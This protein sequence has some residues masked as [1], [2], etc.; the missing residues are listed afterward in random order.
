MKSINL[1]K[2]Q[3]KPF[4]MSSSQIEMESV[5]ETNIKTNFSNKGLKYMVFG[6]W[7][8]EHLHQKNILSDELRDTIF[9]ELCLFA[10]AEE[11]NVLYDSFMDNMN[12]TQKSMKKFISCNKPKTRK[13][14]KKQVEKKPELVETLVSL[15]N[16]IDAGAAVPVDATVSAVPEEKKEK[17][18]YNRKPKDGAT[19]DETPTTVVDAVPVE[20]K[21][22][23]KYNRKPTVV[24][25]P[26]VDVS[27]VVEV[28]A[29]VDVSPVVEVAAVVD[30]P[31]VEVAAVVETPAK[32]VDVPV[33]DTKEKRKYNKK[34][35]ETTT[36]SVPV[37][38]DTKEKRK[39]NKK[40]KMVVSMTDSQAKPETPT[41]PIAEPEPE[42][43]SKE[44]EEEEYDSDEEEEGTISTVEM[45]IDGKKWFVS[46]DTNEVYDPA[47]ID[48]PK[49]I[50]MFD[51]T[52]Q[53]IAFYKS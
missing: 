31:I 29:V 38:A 25:T 1:L 24:E 7:F 37:E 30:V 4:K 16:T 6:F 50:G 34:P 42:P 51:T 10:S 13:T 8:S 22:K 41:I 46:S 11:Q 28:A 43:V 5:V 12:A 40:D 17:R 45:T 27:P 9:K 32:V 20:K 26:V 35:K 14:Q 2:N 52:S 15:A 21:E 33:A 23:R 44:E 49:P 36:E 48:D 19:T 47:C 53:T 18:K 3:S 39:Y